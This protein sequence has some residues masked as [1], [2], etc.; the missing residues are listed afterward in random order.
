MR[1]T[2]RGLTAVAGLLIALTGCEGPAKGKLETTD[3]VDGTGATAQT[4]DTIAVHYTGRLKSGH[5]FDTSHDRGEPFI[6]R[7]GAGEVIKGWDQGIPGMK[8]GGKRKLVIP[9][10]LAYGERSP[11]RSIPPNS[12]L[13]FDVELLKILKSGK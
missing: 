6:F 2:V 13:H 12:E 5:V 7:L 8:E 4:G 3:V 11:S 10:E 9:A 1:A